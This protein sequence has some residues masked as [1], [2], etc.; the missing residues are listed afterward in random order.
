MDFRHSFVIHH[1][2]PPFPFANSHPFAYSPPMKIK[3]LSFRSLTFLLALHL[4]PLA[5]AQQ[6]SAGTA[7]RHSLWKVQGKSTVYLLGSVHALKKENYPLPAVIDTAFSNSPVVVFEADPGALEDPATAFKLM[8]KGK[9]PEGETLQTQLS[10]DNYKA[11]TNRLQESEMPVMIFEKFSPAMA[12]MTLTLL[13]MRKLDL[14]PEN[15]L[16]KHFF[17]LAKDAGKQ[18]VP[19]ETVDFQMDLLTGFSKE[20]GDLM[21][22]VTLKELGNMKKELTD[23]LNAWETGNT[24][25]LSKIL[26]EAM[27]EAPAIYKRLLTDRNR[28]WLPKIQEFANGGTNAIVIV[29]AAHLVGKEGVV[30]LLKAKGLKVTQE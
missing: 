29:G 14:D 12:A 26:H 15:G 4:I 3:S 18:I 22:K 25:K 2:A 13:E 9:L 16:D 21:M 20:E 30:E 27:Q 8:A 23:L 17:H 7:T 11:F 6:K 24:Q 28:N 1:S 5:S 19:L 10:P